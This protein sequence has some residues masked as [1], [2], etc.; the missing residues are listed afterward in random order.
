MAY[1]VDVVLCMHEP[2]VLLR[3]TY[4]DVCVNDLDG[5]GVDV[6]TSNV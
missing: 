2:P 5:S 6:T 4:H 1:E 3:W